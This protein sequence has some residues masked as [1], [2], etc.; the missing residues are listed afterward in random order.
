[1]QQTQVNVQ[2]Q[3]LHSDTH[4]RSDHSVT[5]EVL[6]TEMDVLPRNQPKSQ[7]L[8]TIFDHKQICNHVQMQYPHS[9][10]SASRETP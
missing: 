5:K 4:G 10:R 2:M 9:D 8:K 3:Y 6:Y 1:M 7:V